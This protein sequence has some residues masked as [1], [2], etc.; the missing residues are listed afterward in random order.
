M[1]TKKTVLSICIL[2][3]ATLTACGANRNKADQEQTVNSTIQGDIT[4]PP[5]FVKSGQQNT[6]T[7]PEETIS[8]EE[9]QKQR[10][11]NQ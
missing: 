10:D 3:I 1:K 2:L 4:R 11:E 8:A 5:V 7:N 9:W 6:E